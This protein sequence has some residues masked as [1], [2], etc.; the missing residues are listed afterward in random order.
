MAIYTDIDKLVR[1]INEAGGL[2]QPF[3]FAINFEMTEGILI[4]EPMK[5]R[6]AFF[7]IHGTGN[8][9]DFPINGSSPK[10]GTCQDVTP[11]TK[12]EF[13][14]FPESMEEY[15]GKFAI[16]QKGIRHGNSFLLNLTT[17][18]PVKCRTGL[19]E[20]FLRSPAPYKLYIPGKFVCFSPEAFVRISPDGEISSFP[21]KGTIDA[22]VPNAEQVL[23]ADEKEAQEHYTICD[24]IRND[25][26]IIAEGTRIERFRYCEKI[27]TS[28]GAI[29]QTS[30]EIRARLPENWTGALGDI[31]IKL[32]PAGSISGAPK[33]ASVEIIKEAETAPRGYY[34]GVFGYF[35]GQKLESAVMIRFIAEGPDG[36]YFYSGGGITINSSMEDEYRE[37]IRKV[38]LPE[39]GRFLE[40]LKIE[41]GHICNAGR[42][43]ERIKETL[44]KANINSGIHCFDRLFR[45]LS[46][47]DLK[48]LSEYA[49]ELSGEQDLVRA[50]CPGKVYRLSIEYGYR[51]TGIRIIEYTFR[52]ISSF[53]TVHDDNIEYA[54]KYADRTSLDRLYSQRSGKD[55]IIIIKDG[56]VT[57]CSIGNLVFL[58]EGRY[59]TP[60]TCLLDGLAR[61]ELIRKGKVSVVEITED[62]IQ[63]YERIFVINS[64][65]DS[66]P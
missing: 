62:D 60:D 18:T 20:I 22:S 6:E 13:T 64:M 5:S 47:Q 2:R 38:Y 29:L 3:L 56:H 46:E 32:L 57:D 21:M 26:N 16:V 52:E 23:L 51:P 37:V 58:R 42:H 14:A 54:L 36:Q 27:R 34:T 59:Y 53:M 65:R 40:T 1:E 24:L 35:D 12:P 41:N 50:I 63:L 61:Q 39:P 45:I 55:E 10:T 44:H 11:E 4:K 7:S 25:L 49:A 9:Y 33:K 17:R 8:R 66:L 30:S 48:G 19:D 15:A 31:L 28:T 43:I